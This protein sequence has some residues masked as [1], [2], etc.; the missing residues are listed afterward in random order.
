MLLERR[1]RA[2]GVFSFAKAR[3]KAGVTHLGADEMGR[4]ARDETGDDAEITDLRREIVS[5]EGELERDRG[6][7]LRAMAGRAF[8]SRRRR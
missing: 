7:G 5:I 3:Q 6:R 1:E 4:L 2:S 8:R